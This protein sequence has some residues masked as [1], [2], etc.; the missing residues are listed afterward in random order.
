M[1]RDALES[2]LSAMFDGELPA[3]ECEL[4]SRRLVRE[5]P[6]RATWSRYAV[7][8]AALRAEPVAQV[9]PDFARRISAQLDGGRAATVAAARRG[10]F[11]RASALGGALAA[12][13][14]GT[15]IM[16]LRSGLPI[17]G[18][19]LT[20]YAPTVARAAM[21]AGSGAAESAA[22][23]SH[24]LTGS[25]QTMMAS[26]AVYRSG[27]PSIYVVPPAGAGNTLPIP[28]SLADYVVA[29]SAVSSPLMRRSVLSSLVGNESLQPIDA[30]ERDASSLP[31]SGRAA[32]HSDNAR[33]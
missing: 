22:V 16:V 13:V 26:G 31:A 18:E 5:E 4:L 27:E 8:G 29:H 17:P 12:G 33:P 9:R 7:I 10:R 21:P 6:L 30:V 25:G 1:N 20:V 11:W 2:Q 28:A 14:A 23:P 19:A 32:L 15:A 24:R 3:A